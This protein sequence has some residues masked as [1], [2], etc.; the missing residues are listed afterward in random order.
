M[1]VVIIVALLLG[2]AFWGYNQ[3]LIKIA[4]SVVA[5][6]ASILITTLFAPLITELIKKN[7]DIDEKMS[8]SFYELLDENEEVR[9]Y[10]ASNELA[11]QTV[12]TSG[13]QTISSKVDEIVE[14]I[15]EKFE[16]PE[17]IVKALDKN[18][19]SDLKDDDILVGTTSVREFTL[20]LV[21]A[22][23]ADI[24]FNALVYVIILAILYIVIRLI[25]VFTNILAKLP[26]IGKLNHILGAGLGLC[27]GLIAVWILFIIITAFGNTEF[28]GKLLLEIND[29]SFLAFIYNHNPLST[30]LIERIF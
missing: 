23:L 2:F 21:A 20:H 25:L 16:L 19:K 11:N 14:G 15:G 13:L 24:V 8:Q 29:N 10:L 17:I 9:T 27:E 18:T 1:L 7:T 22:G 5:L 6:I 3:G 28:A 30:L 4:V 12:D 26:I